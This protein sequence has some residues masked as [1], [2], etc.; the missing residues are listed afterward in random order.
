MRLP[1]VVVGDVVEE[2]FALVVD[3]AVPPPA[4]MP[5]WERELA[6]GMWRQFAEECGARAVIVSP[7]R[8]EVIEACYLDASADEGGNAAD[9]VDR[10]ASFLLDR[11]PREPIG[12][13]E[14][15]ADVAMRLLDESRVTVR[16]AETA[17][18]ITVNFAG[19]GLDTDPAA[20]EETPP[21]LRDQAVLVA[22]AF[23]ETYEELAPSYG[24]VTR[25]ET[26]VPW[27]QVPAKNAELMVS[28][29]ATLIERGVIRVSR[30]C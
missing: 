15:P 23:H 16:T 29:A 6:A 12:P 11:F 26:A 9:Q 27:D 7:D 19:P 17:A 28:V 30:S 21:F 8:V 3:Q 24:Y 10:L 20:E 18:P 4:S 2:P 13:D 1:C 22:R 5:G 25:R 14:S